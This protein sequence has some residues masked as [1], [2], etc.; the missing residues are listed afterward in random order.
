MGANQKFCSMVFNLGGEKIMTLSDFD[1]EAAIGFEYPEEN[2]VIKTSQGK[3]VGNRNANIDDAILTVTLPY[4]F[5]ERRKLKEIID[6]N[7][8]GAPLAVDVIDD[9]VYGETN[10][11]TDAFF[12]TG[13]RKSTV[14]APD[15]STRVFKIYCPEFKSTKDK[16]IGGILNKVKDIERLARG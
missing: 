6:L 12:L 15:G 5:S 14:G 13:L 2:T 4:T 16:T 10:R 11:T 8:M 7:M 3:V 9:G 1:K